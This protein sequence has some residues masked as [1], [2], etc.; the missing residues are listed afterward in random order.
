MLVVEAAWLAWGDGVVARLVRSIHDSRRFEDLPILAD[1]L[2][3]AGCDDEALLSHLRGP[4]P[5]VRGCH[6]IDW[7]TGKS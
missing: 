2:D 5:H 3:E 7:L 1:A 4:G 6:V